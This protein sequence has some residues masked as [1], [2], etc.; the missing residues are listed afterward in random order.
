MI[1]GNAPR[2]RCKSAPRASATYSPNSKM[3]SMAD[4]FTAVKNK[5]AEN[6]D[7][8]R[9]NREETC[10][11]EMKNPGTSGHVSRPIPVTVTQVI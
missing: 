8:M 1:L 3:K 2:A 10:I 6:N 5:L 9:I 4:I 7:L 11:L